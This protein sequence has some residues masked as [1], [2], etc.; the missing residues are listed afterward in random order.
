MR[1]DGA[2]VPRQ[3]APPDNDGI[4]IAIGRQPRSEREVSLLA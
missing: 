2:R 4:P 3:A 1:R